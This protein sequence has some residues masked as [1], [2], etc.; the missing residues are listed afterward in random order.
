MVYKLLKPDSF[1]V[2]VTCD[3][4][5]NVAWPR[6]SSLHCKTEGST[7]CNTFSLFLAVI[8]GCTAPLGMETGAISDDH[9]RASS[10]WDDKHPARNARLNFK[11][12]GSFGWTTK[13][14]DFN[15]W[16]QV[17]LYSYTA[18]TGVATQGTTDNKTDQWVTKYWLQYSDDGVAFTFY[19][20]PSENSP[21]VCQL[22]G[23][24]FNFKLP[25]TINI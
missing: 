2:D 7:I 15:Q 22:F 10:Q 17:D 25:T 20:N 21:K 6:L 1:V 16:L 13:H 8:S 14:N 23:V 5:I 12:Q 4:L 11:E 24:A 19:R 9:I 3:W 18:V